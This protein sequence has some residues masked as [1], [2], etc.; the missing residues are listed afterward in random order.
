MPIQPPDNV[1]DKL[2][3]A[4]RAVDVNADPYGA[5]QL[6]IGGTVNILGGGSGGTAQAD[7][8]AFIPTSS[9]LTPAGAYVGGRQVASGHIGAPAMSASAILQVHVV[10]GGAGG[11][12]A[13]LTVKGT[14][15]NDLGVGFASGPAGGDGHWNLPVV[16]GSGHYPTVNLGAGVVVTGSVFVANLGGSVGA[17]G[18]GGT[19]GVVGAGGSLGAVNLGGSVTAFQG[20][21]PWSVVGSVN[22]TPV[23]SFTVNLG[24]GIVGSAAVTPA[25][26]FTVWMANPA[27]GGGGFATV[28]VYG[29]VG[30]TGSVRVTPAGDF[31]VWLA[32]AAAG[33]AL[34]TVGV[35]GSVQVTGSVNVTP[36]ASFTVNLASHIDTAGSALRVNVV[37]GGAGGGVAQMQ[38]QGTSG[39]Y[40]GVG[41]ASGPGDPRSGPDG[42]FALPVL[43]AS[44]FY[45]TVNV[46]VMPAL[47]GSV[48]ATNLGGSVGVLGLGGSFPVVG[49]VNVTPVATFTVALD[50]VATVNLGLGTVNIG[51]GVVG[52]VNVTPVAS[53]TVNLGSI[54]TVN[55][56]LGTVNIG[57]VPQVTVGGVAVVDTRGSLVPTQWLISMGGSG[58]SAISVAS[59]ATSPKTK[60]Y[61]IMLVSTGTVDVTFQ[62]P[63]GTFLTG[64]LRI[65]P[66]AGFA[67]Q[68]QLANPVLIGG[69]NATLFIHAAGSQNIGGWVTGWTEP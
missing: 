35:Y 47:V 66:G 44:G 62:S 23:A 10:A 25:G 6:Q 48:F 17:V 64:S 68:T 59:A 63:S 42:H 7:D 32:N 5:H 57:N 12:L 38:V 61:S 2:Q 53:F 56:G 69:A 43:Y 19:M 49:S 8:S 31:T 33:S 18:A 22:V 65:L 20:A 15:N 60:L 34:G 29:S 67:V 26:D 16:M 36:V 40:A 9:S 41:Y 58:Y 39:A 13:N 14:A 24:S 28:G 51:N 27:A 21:A 1:W 55:V 54:P 45:A 37:A 4:M 52:S 11:G 3:R 50:K 30:V 46:G